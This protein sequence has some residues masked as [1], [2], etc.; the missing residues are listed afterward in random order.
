MLKFEILWRSPRRRETVEAERV[1]P[2]RGFHVFYVGNDV[3]KSVRS[4]LV[5][6]V[7]R[8]P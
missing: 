4:A 8:L 7:T 2:E 5:E 1:V 6:G 3:V